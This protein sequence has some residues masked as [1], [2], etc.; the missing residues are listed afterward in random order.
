MA[1]TNPP[2]LEVLYLPGLDIATVQQ[3]GGAAASD[4]AGLD[5]RSGR[6]CASTTRSWT[7]SS[8]AWWSAWGRAGSGAR[9][10]PR[11]AAARR[12]GVAAG[13]L[14]LAGSA[15][16]PGDLGQASER[17]VAP[18]V[19]HLLGLPRSRELD[20][21]V[22]D[23]GLAGPFRQAHPVRTV[24]SYGGRA[25]GRPSDSGFDRAMLEELKRARL[26]PLIGVRIGR[27]AA[28]LAD[29]RRQDGEPLG[30]ARGVPIAV[31]A[32]RA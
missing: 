30:T 6:S 7:G 21:R 29:E 31:R 20:G 27:I 25:A 26:H 22:L 28:G 13:E 32:P 8:E 15:V 2:D 4:L 12:A 24:D 16:R 14:L 5:A 3:L 19:L 17:D 23:E 1:A 9:G 10:R 11:P 18:T